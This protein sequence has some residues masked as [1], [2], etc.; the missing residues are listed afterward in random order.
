MAERIGFLGPGL[1][2]RGIVKN[3][4][5]KGFPVMVY[6]HREGLNLTELTEAGATVTKSLGELGGANDRVCLCV[7]SSREVEAAVLG[8][9]GL[10]G[11]MKP[12]SIIIDFSTSHPTSTRMLWDRLN[13][14]KVAFLDA[15]MTGTPVH[16]NAGEINLMI[17][18]EKP[19]YEVC[20]PVFRAVAKNI[21]HVGPSSHGNIVKLINNFLGQLTNAAL[22]EVL[23]LAAKAGVDMKGL[24]DAVRVSGGN[25]RMFEGV[26]PAVCSRNFAVSF[27]LRLA[28][29]DMAYLS[30]VGRELDAPLPLVNSLLNVLDLA[31]AS[32]LG[33][34]NTNALVKLYEQIL[35]LEVRG[36]L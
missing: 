20:L 2:G 34:E 15:P 24:F 10:L 31:K 26:V 11:S 22:A 17:G 1:M 32:G 35:H 23:P 28:H 14:K 4:L 7:P 29:K 3:L 30:S 13:E 9:D 16:A 27:E 6:A 18:G 19:A 25:S 5:K 33:R 12:G 21:F 8:P 36:T